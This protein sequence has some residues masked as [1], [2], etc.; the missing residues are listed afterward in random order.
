MEMA[1]DVVEKRRQNLAALDDRRLGLTP[2]EKEICLMILQKKSIN[3]I[4]AKLKR[5]PTAI[6]S[7]RA[8]I[9][10]KLGLVKNDN[11]LEA[12]LRLVDKEGTGP[13]NLQE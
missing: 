3:E 7:A 4:A 2:Y 10:S 8:V 11:L 9:R 6:T 1:A 5:K 12:L 13:H